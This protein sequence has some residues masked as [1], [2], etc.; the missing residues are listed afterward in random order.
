MLLKLKK[1]F[2]A[3]QR[4]KQK[5]VYLLGSD[6]EKEGG[7]QVRHSSGDADYDIAMSACAIATSQ[8]VVVVGNDTNLLILLQYHFNSANH[9]AIYLQTSTKII[10]ISILQRLSSLT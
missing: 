10:D 9:Q 8:P 1:T 7:I 3:N 6:M 5:C 2:L 4:N